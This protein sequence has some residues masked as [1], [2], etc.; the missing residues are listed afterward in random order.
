MRTARIVR[1]MARM[2]RAAALALGTIAL[3]GAAVAY[4]RFLEPRWLSVT[5]VR[6]AWSG[7]PLRIAFASDLHAYGDDAR[8]LRRV[9]ERMN[10]AAPDLA[11]LGGDFIADLDASDAKLR[12]LEPLSRLRARRGVFAVLGNHDYADGARI[13]AALRALGVTVLDNEARVLAPGAALI[14]LGNDRARDVDAARAFAGVPPGAARVV[15]THSW[16]S[17][18]ARGVERFDVALVGH[19]HGGQAC[20]PVLDVCPF[21]EDDMRPFLAGPYRWPNGGVLFVT[22]GIGE[23]G[24]RAR[25]GSRPEVAIVDLV[26]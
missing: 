3:G 4:A 5:R 20:V 16:Q 23:S 6:L 17:L 24:A 26:R 19:T 18:R 9:V 21:A 22:R 11:L 10:A 15:L 1:A 2:N 12:A 8:W 13:T 25:I 7:P 14:A